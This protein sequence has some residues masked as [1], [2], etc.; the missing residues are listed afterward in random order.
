MARV[1]N[2]LLFPSDVEGQWNAVCLDL[3]IW[4]TGPSIA[5]AA[6]LVE[7][8][9]VFS[10]DGYDIDGFVDAD[11][12]YWERFQEILYRAAQ[13]DGLKMDVSELDDQEGRI[14]LGVAYRCWLTQDDGAWRLTPVEPDPPPQKAHKP[15]AA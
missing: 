15:L 8:A 3:N 14:S 10:L 2:F 6:D 13:G 9:V 7:D 12:E 4:T 5:E 1:I 11:A